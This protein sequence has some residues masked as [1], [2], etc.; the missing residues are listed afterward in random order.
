MGFYGHSGCRSAAGSPH[1]VYRS[2][3]IRFSAVASVAIAVTAAS[4]SVG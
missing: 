4:I 3:E 2:L 1:R